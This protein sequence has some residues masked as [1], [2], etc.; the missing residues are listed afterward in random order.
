LP[1]PLYPRPQMFFGQLQVLVN[2]PDV[3]LAIPFSNALLAPAL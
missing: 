1:W 2:E 3:T